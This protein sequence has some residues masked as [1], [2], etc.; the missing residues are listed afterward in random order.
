MAAVVSA[1]SGWVCVSALWGVRTILVPRMV[2]ASCLIS[3]QLRSLLPSVPSVCRCELV[4]ASSVCTLDC[5]VVVRQCLWAACICC[6]R[7][8]ATVVLV[9]GDPGVGSL[10]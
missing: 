3:L 8:H 7:G 10:D 1:R 5:V 2:L 4:L 6:R 9:G